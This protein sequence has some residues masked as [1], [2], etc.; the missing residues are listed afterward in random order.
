MSII[1]A[2]Q[3]KIVT[4]KVTSNSGNPITDL[5]LFFIQN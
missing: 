4:S 2:K 3:S 1:F 5:P